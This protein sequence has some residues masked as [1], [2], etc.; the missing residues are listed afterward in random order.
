MNSGELLVAYRDDIVDVALPYLW[1]DDEAFRYM[2]A[3]YRMFVRLTGGIADFTSDA[4]V[5][6]IVAGEAVADISPSILRIMS[7]NKASDE[8]DLTIINMVDEATTESDDYFQLLRS[9]RSTK[10]GAVRKMIIGAEK[11][12]VRW[13]SVPE[14]ADTVNMHIYRLPIDHIT[15]DSH[16]MS[17]VD[18]EHHTYLLDWMKH[19]AYK[20][21]D[22]ETFDKTK[23]DEA[24]AS[25]RAYCAFC[26]AEMERYKHKTR[27]VEY[28]GC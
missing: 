13:V 24:E 2:D 17:D 6:D 10:T 12:K 19:L 22:A 25:F 8:Q 4:T 23:S 5:V 28:G 1:S 14:V 7:A 20:K 27:V 9:I 15:D 3:A 18:E 26:K 11:N 21:Q 16:T